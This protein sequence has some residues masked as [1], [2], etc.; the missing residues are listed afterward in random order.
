M[1]NLLGTSQNPQITQHDLAILKLKTQR[2]ALKIHYKKI[3]SSTSSTSTQRETTIEQKQI[4]IIKLKQLKQINAQL[5]II[6][7]LTER[8]ETG[9]IN[10]S[11]V[12][13]LKSGALV[14]SSLND[15]VGGIEGVANLLDNVHD[16]IGAIYLICRRTK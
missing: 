8:I 14:L 4:R 12:E 7:E 11:V 6:Q 3:E 2:D 5:A 13:A 1:G 16:G 15:K 9:L 10:V